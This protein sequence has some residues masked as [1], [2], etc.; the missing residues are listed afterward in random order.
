MADRISYVI[1]RG[2]TIAYALRDSNP[3]GHVA[4]TLEVVERLA[5]QRK[6]A[7]GSKP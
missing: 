3:D 5:A 6:A 4:N 7:G 1:A 2:G